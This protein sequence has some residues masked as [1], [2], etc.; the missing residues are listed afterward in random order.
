MS[1][2]AVIMCLVARVPDGTTLICS[3]KTAIRIAG[4]ETGALVPKNA[5][6]QLAALTTGVTI[7]CLP[8]GN[9]GQFIVAKCTLPDRRD[10]ACTLI[11]AKA[12]VRSDASWR[13]Y[14]LQNCD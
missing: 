5:R 10:L 3:D 13:R 6:R 14:G 9:E 11:D 4:L 12:A 8:A 7:S 2:A 1:M